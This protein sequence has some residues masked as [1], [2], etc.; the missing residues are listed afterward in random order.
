MD[1]S[2]EPI[3]ES[4]Q[5]QFCVEMMKRLDIQRRNDHF[6][7]V[8]LEVGSGDDQ[9]RLKAH[10][11]VLC[12][13]SPFFYNA[14]NSDMKEKKEGVIRLEK[15]SKA[16]MEEVLKYLYTGHVD[17]NED[18]ANLF[19]LTAAADYFVI[20]GLKALCDKCILKTLALSNCVSIYYFALKYRCEELQKGAKDFILANFVAVA[21]TE[22]FL[23]LSSK[24]VE[25]WISSDEIIVEGE[26]EVFEVAVKWMERNECQKQNF[27]ELFRHIRCIYLPRVYL[28]NVA[29]HDPLIKN[30][31]DCSNCAQDAIK[32]VLGG[33]EECYFSQSPRN[34]LKT[35]ENAIVACGK[36]STL[37]YI[38][39]ED[40][41]Y[42]L[43][44][45]LSSRYFVSQSISVCQGMLFFIGG[46]YGSDTCSFPAERYDPS[47]NTWSPLDSFN[48]RVKW[49][50]VVTFQGLLYVL[51]GVEQKE[52]KYLSTVQRYNPD[53]KLWQKVS[54]LSS[55][56]SS[57]CAVATGS[58]L[59]AIGGK[60]DVGPVKIVER[61]DPKEKTWCLVTPT[62]EKR[63]SACGA[64]VNEKVFVFGGLRSENYPH[65]SFCEMYDLV[66]DMWSNIPNTVTP[67]GFVSAV[68]FKGNIFVSGQFGEDVS[69]SLHIYNVATSECKFCKFPQRGEKF[70]LSCLRMPIEVLDKCEVLS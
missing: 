22:D 45:M 61:Y 31:I 58:H 64:V 52:N 8:I 9:A 16:V 12:A 19:D 25:E 11:I 50:S 44:G 62:L 1:L 23:N 47:V 2:S 26:E 27:Y 33:G 65:S 38:P 49:C 69:Q 48:Q 29:L 7:D 56:R 3:T 53:T 4:E 63:R 20:P 17:I 6:C 32:M 54:S 14:L 13:A 40:K 24:Q 30:N 15:T 43:S 67:R 55:A 18:N 28:S 5:Q 37:C 41:W 36:N 21:E 59:Y 60:S 57:V 51:G 46:T 66:T 35:H 70:K 34:C 42:K 68:S 10:K 39:V